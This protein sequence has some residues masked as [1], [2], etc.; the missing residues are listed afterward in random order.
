M[1]DPTDSRSPSFWS[2]FVRARLEDANVDPDVSDEVAQHAEELYRAAR[3][4]GRSDSEALALIDR[5]IADLPALLRT[6]REAKQRRALPPAL[7][8]SSPG[9]LRMAAGFWRDVMYGARRL[10][11]RPMFTAVAVITLALGIGANTAI[12]SVVHSVL[13]APLPFADPDRLVM[14][15]ETDGPDDDSAF[16]VA[17]PNW[18]DWTK[19]STSFTATAIWEDLNFNIAGG[20]DPEQVAGLRVSSSVFPMLGIDP[21]LGRTFRPEEDTPGHD[22][23]VI[24]DGLWRRRF[25]ARS[26]IV[27]Q[28]TRVNGQPFEVIGVMPPS[29]AFMD[30]SYA[31]WV[32]I[33][34]TEQDAERGSHSF[35]AAARLRPGVT[36]E[37]ARS[38][39]RAIGVRLAAEYESNK[40]EGAT[41]TWMKDLGVSQLRPTLYALLGAVTMVLL[42][43]CVNVANL[44]LAQA[45]VRQR[46]FAIRAALGAGRGRLAS[47]MLAEGVLLAVVGG[48][49]GIGLA[50]AGT[51]ALA[52]SLPPSIR[53]APFREVTT[54][55]LNPIVLAFTFGLATLTGIL[56]SL[57]P[58][59]GTAY[60]A[61]AS[62]LQSSGTRGG[63][64]YFSVLRSL[65]VTIEVALAVIVLAAAGLMIKSVSRLVAVD[66][67][68]DPRGVLTMRLALPQADTY[69]PPTRTTF[70]DDVE[71][72]VGSLPGVTSVAAMSHLPLS[73]ANAGRGF[74]IEGRPPDLPNE[75][76]SAS[77]RLTCP[78]YFRTLGIPIVKGRDF[79]LADTTTSAAVVI[80]NE[81]TALRYWPNQDPIGHR[82]K[83]G[84]ATS[85][86]SW[87]TVV[88]VT[89]NVRHFGLDADAQREIFRPYSQATWPAMTVIV[90]AASESMSMAPA[91]R[92]ALAK[93]AP[94]QPVSRIRTMEQVVAESVGSRRFPML[95]LGLFSAVALA[96]AAI[97]VYGVVNYVVSQRM[98]EMGIRMALGARAWQVTQ[99]VLKR[100]LLPIGAGI[101]AGIAGSLA[102][103]RMLSALLYEV[104]PGDP[105]VLG[106]I[107]LILGSTAIAACLVP[108]RR[109][110]SVDPLV[111]LREE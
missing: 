25:G 84:N 108:A 20:A 34:F 75:G 7:E 54:V 36:F 10:A 57:A 96:L 19:Q 31:V 91:V 6:V 106:T 58:M 72:E 87:M 35:R 28:V 40:G 26:D 61:T 88:G 65:L 56:F 11:A 101:V 90:K 17:A 55:P 62:T 93:V 30:K 53:S 48:V 104:A 83:L 43:A 45:A 4:A 76:P 16:I 98:R 69:G 109:A 5:D 49:A 21:Q 23:V 100:S 29:F 8:P 89:K 59:A 24:S 67:G 38:E 70:C 77:Y 103:T 82:F 97:G 46:E 105:A 107:V 33:A 39:L 73:G 102:A 2:A 41:I 92:A 52:Q 95:L 13:L 3:I 79:T 32:P 9:A 44:L 1:P 81:A 12:F 78:G 74:A 37:T 51:T 71:R 80:V 99:L 22:V 85:S 47:Q 68:L 60:R 111:V 86:N 14:M 64:A 27:G 50:W 42:I 94:D 110:A 63:T 15:W 18:Q 66:P